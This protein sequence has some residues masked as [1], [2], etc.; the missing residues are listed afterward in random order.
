MIPADRD[1]TSIMPR[2]GFRT[3]SVAWILVLSAASVS[4]AQNA[5]NTR[6]QTGNGLGL[7]S[8]DQGTDEIGRAHV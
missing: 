5:P 3:S 8:L 4:H 2:E 7:Q 6:S 1:D